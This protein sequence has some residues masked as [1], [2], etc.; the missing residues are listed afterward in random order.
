[1]KRKG[2]VT[3]HFS[4][5]PEGTSFVPNSYSWIDEKL[6]KEYEEAGFGCEWKPEKKTIKK[7]SKSK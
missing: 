3:F 7:V 4:T 6:A 2:Q 1:M 5:T